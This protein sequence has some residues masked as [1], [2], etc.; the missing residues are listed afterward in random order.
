MMAAPPRS[1]G[2]QVTVALSIL[3]RLAAEWL[4]ARATALLGV[5][6]AVWMLGWILWAM[7]AL[8]RIVRTRPA[9]PR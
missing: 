7:R 5:S 8:P 4:P 9:A 6:G 3:A 1:S 2:R